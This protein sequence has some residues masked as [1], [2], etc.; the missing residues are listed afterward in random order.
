MLKIYGLR[1]CDSCRKALKWLDKNKIIHK[2]FDIR[3][4]GLTATEIRC[5]AKAVGWNTL[6]NRRSLTWRNLDNNLKEC[7]DDE[8]LVELT[9]KNP[10]L[11]KRPIIMSHNGAIVGFSDF[12]KTKIKELL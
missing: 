11:I 2:Y 4:E 6:L 3:S 5:L 9:L 8:N 10:T 12:Q 1:N 7:F